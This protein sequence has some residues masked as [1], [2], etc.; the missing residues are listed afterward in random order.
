MRVSNVYTNPVMDLYIDPWQLLTSDQIFFTGSLQL[1]AILRE[2]SIPVL[3]DTEIDIFPSH[4][5][6]YKAVFEKEVRLLHLLPSEKIESTLKAVIT[7]TTLENTTDFRALSYVWGQ[8]NQ[9]CVLK[10]PDGYL[11]ITSSVSSALR[12]LRRS[13]DPITLWVDAVCINQDDNSEKASQIKLLPHIFR[14]A[15]STLA[16]LTDDGSHDDAIEALMQIKAKANQSEVCS[17]LGSPSSGV[18]TYDEREIYKDN[19]QNISGENEEY[20]W[21]SC[22]PRVP[23]SWA[24]EPMPTAEDP[25]WTDINNFFQHPWFRRIW[26]VQEVVLSSAV[27]VLSGKWV[28]DWND[29]LSATE[30]ID[31]EWYTCNHYMT[32]KKTWGPFLEIATYRERESRKNR[33]ALINLLESFRHA[34]STL[35][36]D[37]IFALLGFAADGNNRGFEPD[38]NSPFEDILCRVAQAFIQQGRILLLLYRAGLDDITSEDTP[39]RFPSW[40]PNW[41]KSKKP[42]LW[43]SSHRGVQFSASWKAEPWIDDDLNPDSTHEITLHG[44]MVDYITS[45]SVASCTENQLYTFLR[46]VDTMIDSHVLEPYFA[47]SISKEDLKW[48]VPVAGARYPRVTTDVE[49]DLQNSYKAL[50]EDLGLNHFCAATA[51][52]SASAASSTVGLEDCTTSENYKRALFECVEGWHFFITAR[53]YVG[54]GPGAIQ[55]DDIISIFDGSAVPF[56]TRPSFQRGVNWVSRFVGECY[57]HGLMNGEAE[58]LDNIREGWFTLH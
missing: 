12:H 49:T 44:V 6:H 16:F 25:V 3:R 21:P 30:V 32:M 26:I 51:S 48:Q 4:E 35:A 15:M 2:T 11:N 23:C 52:S 27:R 10:T 19:L 37:R 57:I 41:A 56:I 42:C 1:K 28:I 9:S 43:E 53:G 18:R 50:R 38:Y 54:I 55:C 20:I 47:R 24:D 17:G 45:I 31:R 39:A 29:L 22:L 5:Y 46:E 34:E 33:M 58:H 36:R 40:I 7:H 14:H 8:G 13:Y